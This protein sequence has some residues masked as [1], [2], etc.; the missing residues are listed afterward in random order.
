MRDFKKYDIWKEGIHLVK[1]I[2]ALSQNLPSEEKFGL[3][4]QMSR[5]AVSIPSNIA[6]GCG[7]ETEKDF[8]RFLQIAL[9]SAFELETQIIICNELGFVSNEENAALGSDV[10]KIQ[11]QITSLINR[12]SSNT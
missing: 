1:K 10:K 7:R 2:Y 8:K 9:G 4:S 3:R 6:E 12:I 11:K 5:C